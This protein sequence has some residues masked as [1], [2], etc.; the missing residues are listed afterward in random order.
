MERVYDLLLAVMNNS[1]FSLSKRII[2]K[3]FR[4]KTKGGLTKE[5]PMW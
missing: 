3:I 1:T 5:H 2:D 4:D